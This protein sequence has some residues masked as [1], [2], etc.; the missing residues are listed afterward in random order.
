MDT[1]NLNN[2]PFNLTIMRPTSDDLQSFIERGLFKAFDEYE[3]LQLTQYAVEMGYDI[4]IQNAY[5]EIKHRN[6]SI[7]M[8]CFQGKI[9]NV[10]NINGNHFDFVDMSSSL[11]LLRLIPKIDKCIKVTPKL[12]EIIAGA[13]CDV[14][15]TNIN[16]AI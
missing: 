5:A 16:K 2:T 15:L 11:Y 14:N 3:V 7:F 12:K 1:T 6:K 13:F 8:V 4:N 10:T 9:I